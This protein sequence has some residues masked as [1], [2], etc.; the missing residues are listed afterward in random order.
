MPAVQNPHWSAWCSWKD[1]C[2]GPGARPSIVRTSQPSAWTASVRQERH[3]LA[4]ELDGAGAADAVLAAD[5][6]A[7]QARGRG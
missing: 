7:G 4:V 5:L 3:G 2:S 6:R 1:A